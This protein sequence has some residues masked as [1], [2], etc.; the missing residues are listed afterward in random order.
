MGEKLKE[1]DA[2]KYRIV[3][4]VLGVITRIGAIFCWIG[5]VAVALV[6][7]CAAIVAPNI[8][9]DSEA[10]EI[11]LFDS[12]ANY[13]IKG[14]DLEIGEGENKIAVK[15]G[16]IIIGDRDTS[17]QLSDADIKT[18]EDFIEN[19]VMKFI[20]ASPYV[21]TLIFVSILF[22]ALA[23]G[24]CASTLKNIATK[25]SPF[26][27]DNIDR[28]ERAAKYVL[29]SLVVVFI[30]NFILDIVMDV[31]GYRFDFS[32]VVTILG[33]YVAVY[34]FKYGLSLETKKKEKTKED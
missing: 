2:K 13:D 10:K 3:S 12:T 31:R 5:A 23:L 6:A 14:K 19:D 29:I 18:I 28:T 33:L 22:V 30:A 11:T 17:I 15:D 20:A 34:V 1:E 21:F 27:Q 24:H 26:I 8:K 4:R 16:K 7:V 32:S 25:E 9:I